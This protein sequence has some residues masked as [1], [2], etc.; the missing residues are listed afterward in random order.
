VT[1]PTGPPEERTGSLVRG[2]VDFAAVL[3]AGGVRAAPGRL[4]E[5]A[6]GLSSIDV[7]DYHEFFWALRCTIPESPAEI[8]R[9]DAAFDAFWRQRFALEAPGGD[10]PDDRLSGL[11]GEG[12]AGG[13][14]AEEDTIPGEAGRS[15]S[16]GTVLAWPAAELTL[17]QVAARTVD[18]LSWKAS[19]RFRPARRGPVIDAR[20]TMRQSHSHGGVPLVLARRER[21]LRKARVVVICDVSRSMEPF[22]R[23][24][25]RYTAELAAA[26]ARVEAFVFSLH[27][28]RITP[29]FRRR[30]VAEALR[31][32]SRVSGDWKAG[33]RIGGSLSEFVRR[34][35]GLLDRQT[36]VFILS[37]GL[38]TEDPAMIG[39]SLKEMR[40]LAGAVVWLNP[41]AASPAFEPRT[42]AMQAALPHLDLLASGHS[43]EALGE[44]AAVLADLRGGRRAPRPS[45]RR[46]VIPAQ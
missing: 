17:A 16:D 35:A 42:R 46:P 29:A 33:T 21:R 26:T 38:D 3:R 14:D 8:G 4:I 20:R 6:A 22:V 9:F 34:Y 44:V 45:G 2:L 28:A 1:L 37:D 30:S 40:R 39:A 18:A 32:I 7:C 43:V 41:L 5:A 31:A 12:E 19:R 25:L 13:P 23:L 15:E 24:L 36:A 10:D 11:A 27:L